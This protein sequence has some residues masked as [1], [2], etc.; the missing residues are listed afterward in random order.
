MK[1][2]TI[3]RILQKKLAEW[4]ET[5]EDEQ[6]RIALARNSIISGGCFTSLLCGEGYNDIDVYFRD[7]ETV[8]RVMLYYSRHADGL[9]VC[10]TDFTNIRGEVESRYFMQSG[11]GTL[12]RVISVPEV[13]IRASLWKMP[14]SKTPYAPRVFTSNAIS[15]NNKIQL[16]TRFFGEPGKIHSNYDFEHAKCWYDVGTQQLHIPESAMSAILQ[17]R[18][19]YTGSLYPLCSLL[20]TRKFLARGWTIDLFNMLRIMTDVRALNFDDMRTMRDQLMG[21]DAVY[22]SAALD[23]AESADWATFMEHLGKAFEHMEESEDDGDD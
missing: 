21:V 11:D 23:I 10:R 19:V 8:E 5:V 12:A 22:V 14:K 13:A 16:I 4:L 18:L 7:A 15:L 6:L 3:K 1:F 17:K 2:A 20:R 9:D